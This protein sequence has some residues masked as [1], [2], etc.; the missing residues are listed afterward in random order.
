LHRNPLTEDSF[1][2][3]A[4]RL[5]AVDHEQPALLGVQSACDQVREQLG[6]HRRVLARPLTHSQQMLLAGWVDPQSHH[7]VMPREANT[8]DIDD[9]N[10]QPLEALLAQRLEFLGARRNEFAADR[11]TRKPHR[12]GHLRHYF[13]VVASRNSAEQDLQH[14]CAGAVVGLERLI[15]RHRY[16]SANPTAAPAQADPLDLE[17]AIRQAHLPWLAAVPDHLT[18][19]AAALRRA[20]YL[21]RRQFQ[22]RLDGRTPGHID[23][24]FQRDLGALYQLHQGQQTLTILRQPVRQRA[25]VLSA[26]YLIVLLH[27]GSLLTVQRDSTRIARGGPPSLLSSSHFHRDIAP[28]GTGTF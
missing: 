5:G 21:Q 22:H 27:G 11:R 15:R 26:D 18:V 14:P 7:H 12:L 20:R 13:G 24:F 23:Q 28:V 3:G 2:R 1:D 25:S 9:K 19:A 16:F 8:V 4:Q 10:F 17:L 6:H